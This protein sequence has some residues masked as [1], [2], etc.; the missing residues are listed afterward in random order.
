MMEQYN[1]ETQFAVCVQNEE[2]PVSL[3]LCKIYHVIPDAQSA[4][5]QLLRVIDESGQDYLYPADCFVPIELPH[6][7]EQVVEQAFA[8]AA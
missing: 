3:E 1:L 5:H 8:L 7:V 4:E 2:Y 6:V